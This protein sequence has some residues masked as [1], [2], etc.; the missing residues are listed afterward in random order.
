MAP[1]DVVVVVDAEVPFL[2]AVPVALC[3]RN[4]SISFKDN[5]RPVPSYLKKYEFNDL[6]FAKG[7]TTCKP[8][9]GFVSKMDSDE[10]QSIW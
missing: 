6:L 8:F 4:C 10:E 3:D 1:P 5:E 9:S 7:L 2:V